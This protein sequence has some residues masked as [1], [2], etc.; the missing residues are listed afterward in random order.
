M[1]QSPI[2]Q[3]LVLGIDAG[4]SK[5][6]ALLADEHGQILGRGHAPGCNFQQHPPEELRALLRWAA[7]AAFQDAYPSLHQAVS[8]SPLLPISHTP[9]PP[10]SHTPIHSIDAL[11]IGMGGADR[12]DEIE[13]LRAL[14]LEAVPVKGSSGP[15]RIQVMN[16]GWLLLWCETM[17]GWGVGLISGTG[18]FAF[19]HDRQ[20]HNSRAGGWGWRMGDEGSGYAMGLAALNAVT[21]AAD[22]R[23]PATCLTAKILAHWDL[24]IPAE[25]IPKV[26]RTALT[27]GDIARLAPLV[28]QAADEGDAAARLIQEHAARS[29]AEMAAAVIRNLDLDKKAPLALGGGV[30]MHDE[31]TASRM[32][33]DLRKMGFDPQP[34]V[35]VEEPARGAIRL[36]TLLLSKP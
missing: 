9:T 23:A 21:R 4:S 11:V 35:R 5:T 32:L 26:Y 31:F 3:S 10:V 7:A 12:P 22:G 28:Q 36:A 19:G 34:V 8:P 15:R 30:L 27:P 2:Q 16:D 18:S 1:N 29:L 17:P 24:K 33:A 25:L 14:A 20:S 13:R 6:T